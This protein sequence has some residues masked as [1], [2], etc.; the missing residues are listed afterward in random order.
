MGKGHHEAG[1]ESPRRDAM[2][3]KDVMSANVITIGP[4]TAVREIVAT[5]LAHHIGGLPVID[6]GRVVGMVG[7]GELVHRHE[8]GTE[9]Q[10]PST[11]WE[12]LL[13]KAPQSAIYVRSHGVRAGDIM[14]PEVTSVTVDTTLGD[15]ATLFERREI[16]RLAVLR[17]DVLV[18]IVT[19][20]DLVRAL[21]AAS[22][23]PC[24]ARARTDDAIRRSLQSELERQPWWPS[25]WCSVAVS[26]G[27]VR[28]TG[29]SDSD[30]DRQA[31][32]VAAEN[33]PGVQGVQDDRL[34]FTDWQPM[35]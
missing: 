16:R 13:G 11:W 28:Y 5:L 24:E 12:R 8:I 1:I 17:G 25:K 4:D 29:I 21:A 32:R 27:R 10:A 34:Q 7:E 35:V 18:G 26:R 33:I 2:E 23:L 22:G 30:I 6:R 31:A 3:V 20:A 19:R 9:G 14:N 15:V